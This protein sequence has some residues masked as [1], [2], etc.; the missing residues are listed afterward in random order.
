FRREHRFDARLAFFED[1]AVAIG[2]LQ[3]EER[4]GELAAAGENTESADH[5]E[6]RYG[7]RAQ[8]ERKIFF[9][10]GFDAEFARLLDRS[11]DADALHQTHRDAIERMRQCRAQ[12]HRAMEFIVIILWSPD[13]STG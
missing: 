3:N 6:Q 12:R 11:L 7:R 4:L 5:L 1:A 2:N 13:F 8:G 9:D 10:R